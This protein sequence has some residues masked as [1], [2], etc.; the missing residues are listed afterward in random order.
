MS[1]EPLP[2]IMPMDILREDFHKRMQK[3]AVE[4]LQG[5][6]GVGALL[7]GLSVGELS[8]LRSACYAISVGRYALGARRLAGLWLLN[9]PR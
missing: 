3:R 5:A 9:S 4:I 8:S 6:A 7:S 2:L 1:N